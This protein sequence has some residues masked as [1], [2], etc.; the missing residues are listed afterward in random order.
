[1]EFENNQPP[2]A[3]SEQE[4]LL[5]QAKKVTIQPANP[6]LKPED[7]PEPVTVTE[8]HQNVE[9]DAEDTARSGSLIQPSPSALRQTKATKSNTRLIVIGSIVLVVIIVASAAFLFLR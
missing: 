6:F 9:N 1:M 7:T 4:R 8:M 2:A 3:A 5:A